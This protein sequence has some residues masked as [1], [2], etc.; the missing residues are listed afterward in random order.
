MVCYPASPERA[1][2]YQVVHG[3]AAH[4]QQARH[5]PNGE[6]RLVQYVPTEVGLNC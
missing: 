1:A 4:L 2:V 5:L 3:T 6:E